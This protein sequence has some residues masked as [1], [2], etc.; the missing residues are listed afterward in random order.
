MRTGGDN[1]QQIYRAKG[2]INCLS[3]S[4]DGEQLLYVYQSEPGESFPGELRLLNVDGSGDRLLATNLPEPGEPRFYPTWSPDGHYVAFVQLDQPIRFDGTYVILAWSNVYVVDTSTEQI[5]RLSSFEGREANYPAWSLDGR[6]V[7]F[8][9]TGRLEE[10]TLY[11]EVWVT[12]MDGSMFYPMS[13]TRPHNALAWLPSISTE[14][15]R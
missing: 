10:D 11:S 12:S 7:V 1:K 3:W 4:P 5:T 13:G 2:G 9:S 6:L 8:V 14:E 15:V